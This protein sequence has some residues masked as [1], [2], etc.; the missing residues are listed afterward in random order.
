MPK[1]PDC[2]GQ[3]VEPM[4]PSVEFCEDCPHLN[5]CVPAMIANGHNPCGI[6]LRAL[7]AQNEASA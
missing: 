7:D 4:D 1:L 3:A 2:H 6:Q 5:T